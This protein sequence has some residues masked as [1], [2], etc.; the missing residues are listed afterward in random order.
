VGGDLAIACHKR[1]AAH[2]AFV[3]GVDGAAVGQHAA[4]GLAVAAQRLGDEEPISDRRPARLD[5]DLL[6]VTLVGGTALER[7]HLGR[8]ELPVCGHGER[9]AADEGGGCGEGD[10]GAH[11]ARARPAAA[12]RL[13]WVSG[14]SGL[15]LDHDASRL[16]IEPRD[17][18]G[19][20]G[21]APGVG[22]RMLP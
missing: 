18:P 4:D 2:A 8:L 15:R 13:L 6:D 20:Q 1:D 14:A 17:L 12:A 22:R 11:D 5:V 7:D 19:R 9:R 3:A 10:G 16:D 21:P